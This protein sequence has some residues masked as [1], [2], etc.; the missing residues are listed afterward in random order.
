[1]ASLFPVLSRSFS[2]NLNERLK[3]RSLDQLIQKLYSSFCIAHLQSREGTKLNKYVPLT[4]NKLYLFADELSILIYTVVG[5]HS[6]SL[7]LFGYL[8]AR[9]Y[10]PFPHTG[11]INFCGQILCHLTKELRL[12]SIQRGYTPTVP[13]DMII[14]TVCGLKLPHEGLFI[15]Q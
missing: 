10:Q 5:V 6:T 4:E 2:C 8:F 9:N 15:A 3:D 7:M 1:M 13:S 11:M 12:K 14:R